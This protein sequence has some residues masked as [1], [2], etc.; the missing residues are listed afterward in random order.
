MLQNIKNVYY[1]PVLIKK[2]VSKIKKQADTLDR[3]IDIMHVCGTH[4]NSIVRFGLRDLLPESIK[5]RAG[6]GCPVCVTSTRDIDAIINFA[7]KN[8][9]TIMSFGDMLK[10]PGSEYSFHSAL[11]LGLDIKMVY[12]VEDA[13]KEAEISKKEIIFFSVGFETTAAPIAS[14]LSE[15][16]IPDNFSI[17]S[18][19]KFTPNGV[20]ELLKSG[21]INADGLLLPGHASVI[22][23][24][25]VYEKIADEFHLASVAS[26]F[27]PLD[28]LVS[29]YMILQQIIDKKSVVENEYKRTVAYEGNKKALRYMDKVFHLDDSIWRGLGNIANSGF[30][31]N[32]Q[33]KNIDA[34]YKF[35]IVYP[36]NYI[37]HKKGCRCADVILGNAEPKDCPLFAKICTPSN[38][39]GPCMVSD[40][41]TC[42]NVYDAGSIE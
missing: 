10:V 3:E 25:K 24:L 37:E 30:F 6:P 34:S 13:I 26:G 29:V 5:L 23:G 20:Y 15:V 2:I 4:E 27:E 7:L 38:P 12:G 36:E 40:E 31:V 1:D 33:F 21:K 19:H 32:E 9:V 35:D 41:G 17:Y 42:K 18:V 22:S 16:F 14:I 39:I 11:S 8:D 28:I